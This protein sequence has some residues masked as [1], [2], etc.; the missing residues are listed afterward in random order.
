MNVRVE[1]KVSLVLLALPELC[2]LC[3]RDVSVTDY[4][5]RGGSEL[6]LRVWSVCDIA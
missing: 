1:E 3:V 5:E 2:V 6:W 4:K